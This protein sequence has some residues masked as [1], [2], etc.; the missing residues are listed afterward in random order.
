MVTPSDLCY[1]LGL[2]P[3][4]YDEDPSVKSVIDRVLKSAVFQLVG[5]VGY[6]PDLL[7]DP[8]AEQLVLSMACDAYEKRDD[9]EERTTRKSYSSHRLMNI[10]IRQQLRCEYDYVLMQG[11]EETDR[12]TWAEE[13]RDLA[14]ADVQDE[15]VGIYAMLADLLDR[16]EAIYGG[17]EDG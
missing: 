13:L 12:P 14:E 17:G 15:H 2:E 16:W 7:D 6:H 11:L 5:E 9:T 4:W 10:D 3:E 1:H 8:R